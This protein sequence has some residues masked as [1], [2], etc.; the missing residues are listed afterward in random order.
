MHQCNYCKCEFNSRKQVKSPIACLKSD[1]QKKRQRD[2]ERIWHEKQRDRF[3]RRYHQ[4][5]RKARAAA[6]TAMIKNI[7]HA[8]K[9][10]FLLTDQSFDTD[11][12][13]T[14]LQKFF[15]TQ[16]LRY[17]NKLWSVKTS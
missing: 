5:R 1:C 6:I 13:Q 9:I 8:A 4:S 14:F 12:F 11:L 2:N 10:G 3:D 15:P 16:G 7:V 17:A